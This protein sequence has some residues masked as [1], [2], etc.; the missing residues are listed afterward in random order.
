MRDKIYKQIIIN[1]KKKYKIS[2]L[3]VKKKAST[4]ENKKYMLTCH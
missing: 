3:K 1:E 4:K 2:F